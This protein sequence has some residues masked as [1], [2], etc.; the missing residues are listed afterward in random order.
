MPDQ[1]NPITDLMI[2]AS[3]AVRVAF[4]EL[5][6]TRHLY[7]NI[8][9]DSSRIK[10]SFDVFKREGKKVASQKTSY[11]ADIVSALQFAEMYDS[12]G[13]LINAKWVAESEESQRCSI[14]PDLQN[15]FEYIRFH[16]AT[17]RSMCSMCGDVIPFNLKRANDFV[18]TIWDSPGRII[19]SSNVQVFLFAYQCQG[20]R[21]VP[22]VFMVRRSDLKIT[23]SGRAPI[24]Q[25][26]VPPYIPKEERQYYSDAII[27]HNSGQT[28]AGLFLLRTFIEQYIRNLYNRSELPVDQL[29][30]QYMTSLPPDF[31]SR[32]PSLKEMYSQLSEAIH[33]AKA[34]AELF[35]SIIE[36]LNRYFDAKRI[37]E[38]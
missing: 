32:F 14:G 22:E 8:H 38:I 3:E 20:C 9:I 4:Q 36:K 33:M 25:I 17:I 23:L 12:P 37:F 19:Q 7:Q 21:S 28:L 6:E 35:T 13:A 2:Q 30:E 27:A 5:L 16:V 15:P 26:Q 18:G 24:E 34:P 11:S 29:I 10:L 31:K 1:N